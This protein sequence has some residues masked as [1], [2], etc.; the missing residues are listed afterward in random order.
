MQP[1]S[2]AAMQSGNLALSSRG[3]LF[4]IP[5][6]VRGAP[7]E[8]WQ[9][10]HVGQ[11][12]AGHNRFSGGREVIEPVLERIRRGLPA[13]RDGGRLPIALLGL[14]KLLL[15]VLPE[16]SHGVH[17]P[18]VF[19]HQLLSLLNLLVQAPVQPAGI[20]LPHAQLALELLHHALLILQL[21]APPLIS[22]VRF[23]LQ[24]LPTLVMLASLVELELL[25]H[26]LHALLRTR[27]VL[28]GPLELL[29]PLRQLLAHG[30]EVIRVLLPPLRQLLLLVL[31]DGLRSF[32]A[33]HLLQVLVVRPLDLPL[34]A[35][36]D[37]AG[38]AQAALGVQRGQ[39]GVL[40]LHV[41]TVAQQGLAPRI[42]HAR[43]RR[44][45]PSA[46]LAHLCPACPAVL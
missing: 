32:Q 34:C 17:L 1:C 22:F 30:L 2:H 19:V 25:A 3:P 18:E 11:L 4:A 44:L 36:D 41:H 20:I 8:G 45:A 21:L 42:E 43:V 39:P 37:T 31:Q 15:G 38:V 7:P 16:A 40:E 29:A 12:H 9:P 46:G 6:G 10:R 13:M 24:V 33:L 14:L 23:A 35:E 28:P 26:H 5:S 27:E